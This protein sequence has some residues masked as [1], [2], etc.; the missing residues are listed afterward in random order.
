MEI[1]ED[2]DPIK[3]QQ[4]RLE[5]ARLYSKNFVDKKH[6]FAKIYEGIINRGV[7]G[8]KLRD[9]PSNLESSLSGD[10]V[11]KEI[12][13]KL[14]EVGSKTIAP[15]QRFCL[16]TK[17]HYGL[18]KYYPTDRQLKLVKEYNRTFSVDE[19]KEIILEAMKPMGQEYAEKLAIA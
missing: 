3:D 8:N 15:F 12:Y 2:S 6:T 10:N 7:E 18:E 14:L 4:K 13:L 9:Y 17:N 5:A 19:A 11:S 1:L 16:I